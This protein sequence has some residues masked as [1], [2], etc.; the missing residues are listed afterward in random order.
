MEWAMILVI[1]LS[2]FLALFLALAIALVI[3]L[4]KVTKQI[5]SVTSTAERA[6]LKF[7]STAENISKFS[8]PLVLAK[9]VTSFINKRK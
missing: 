5:K 3:M 7:E 2:I 4:M 8:S 6:A 1:I 9:L